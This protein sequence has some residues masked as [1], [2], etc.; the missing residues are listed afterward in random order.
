MPGSIGRIRR[1]PLRETVAV[2]IGLSVLATLVYGSYVTHGGFVTDPWVVKGWYQQTSAHD[3]IS[4]SEAYIEYNGIGFS[5]ALDFIRLAAQSVVLGWNMKLWLAWQVTMC[6]IMSLTLFLLLRKLRFAPLHA[7]AMSALV[8]IFPAATSIRIWP[9]MGS[10]AAITLAVLGFLVALRAFEERG[11][12]RPA[13]HGLSLSLF[14]ASAF[15]YE[16]AFAAML[17]SVLVYRFRVPWRAALQRWVFDLGALSVVAVLLREHASARGHQDLAGMLSH[18]RTIADQTLTLF[19]AEVLPLGAFDRWVVAG[20]LAMIPVAA[21]LLLR[22]DPSGERTPQLRFWLWALA[23]GIVLTALGYLSF[24]PADDYYEPLSPGI[25]NRVNAVPQ[26]GLVLALY[27]LVM[28]GAVLAT[29]RSSSSR[30]FAAV[31]GLAVCGAIAIPWLGTIDSEED[32]FVLAYKEEN[33]VVHAV[34]QAVPAP[35]PGGTIWAF[36]Q[37]MEVA[38]GVPIFDQFGSLASRLRLTYDDLALNGLVGA[39]GTWFGCGP[40]AIVPHGPTYPDS[41]DTA[42]LDASTYGRTYFVDTGTGRGE[43][44][45]APKQCLRA[46]A[47]LP[48]PAYLPGEPPPATPASRLVSGAPAAEL[49]GAKGIGLRPGAVT[50]YVDYV[51]AEG[52]TVYLS[53]WTAAADLSRPSAGAIAVV[54]GS[55]VARAQVAGERPDVVRAFNA[56][57]L[58]DSGFVLAVPKTSLDCAALDA[59]VKVVGTV[60]GVGTALQLV[61]NSAQQLEAAC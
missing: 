54:D 27:A 35:S 2:G 16:A 32:S 46:A 17:C 33:R 51:K 25:G 28:L 13:L 38:P 40:D 15:L 14:V 19:T 9:I 18:A 23:A 57:A 53:G 30:R 43:L 34:H 56:P 29:A 1:S 61:G 36:G 5:R 42:D 26:I 59:G 41:G 48:T 60:G 31:G 50:G 24:V 58:R 11:W 20:C 44:V 22:R 37:P 8:L 49:R 12:R 6:V 21:I 52:A 3:L 47:R 45:R 4:L 7:A 10:P 39:P 55:V